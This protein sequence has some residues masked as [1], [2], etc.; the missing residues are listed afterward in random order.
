MLKCTHAPE[1]VAT[2]LEG[3][4]ANMRAS[5][6]K[7]RRFLQGFQVVSLDYVLSTWLCPYLLFPWGFAL[8]RLVVPQPW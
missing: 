3:S 8:A 4:A 5:A 1:T 2:W 6:D 7:C